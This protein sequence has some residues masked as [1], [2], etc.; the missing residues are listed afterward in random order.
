MGMFVVV[1][2]WGRSSY[3]VVGVKKNFD[4]CFCL[5]LRYTGPI[6]HLCFISRFIY[7][8]IYRYFLLVTQRRSCCCLLLYHDCWCARAQMSH[9][10]YMQRYDMPNDGTACHFRRPRFREEIIL[11][12]TCPQ[13]HREKP[14]QLSRELYVT[15]YT[16]LSQNAN[17]IYILTPTAT[18][19]THHW[20]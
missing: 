20:F 5:D 1:L 9:G 2:M 4:S 18:T 10:T 8:Y 12:T 13:Q 16:L 6:T 14:W 11:Y 3:A 7:L 15:Q 17:D 19:L